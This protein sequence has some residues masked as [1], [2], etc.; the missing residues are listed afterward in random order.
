MDQESK[1]AAPLAESH[2]ETQ[3]ET[4]AETEEIIEA[5]ELDLGRRLPSRSL[6]RRILA[7]NLMVLAIP[8]GGFF[9]LNQI[10]ASL[11][12]QEFRG[13]RI[14]GETF[15]GALGASAVV[16]TP[17]RGQWLHPGR[18]AD[19]IRRLAAPT[20]T[21]ARLFDNNGALLADSLALGSP[22]GVVRIQELPPPRGWIAYFDFI[23]D[24]FD[25]LID[26]RPGGSELAPY[27]ESRSQSAA[28]Y[29]EVAR[30]LYGQYYGAMRVD[31]TGELVL[32]VAVPVQRF[33]QVVGAIMLSTGADKIEQGMREVRI[34]ILRVSA[35]ALGVTALL[36]LYLAG[37]I[38]RPLSRLA[39]AAQRVRHAQGRSIEIPDLTHRGDE[40]GN[41]SQSMRDMT[42]ALWARMDAIERFAAD[43]AHEIKNP[44]TS[45]RSAVET[46]SRVS[47]PDQQLRLFEVILEDV[48]RLDRLISD[49]SS[50]SRL[51]AELS[52]AE[53]AP[54]DLGRVLQ[55]VVSIANDRAA[56]HGRARIEL[57]LPGGAAALT[58]KAIESRLGQV[59][60]NVF[61]N[62]QS[63]APPDS[64]I[65]CQARPRGRQIVVTIDDSGPGIPEDSLESI[66][67]RF[68]SDRPKDTGEKFGTHSGLGLNISRQIVESADGSI[69]AANRSDAD[70]NILGARFS[71]ALPVTS[72]QPSDG[73]F[74]D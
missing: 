47:S 32:S 37:T 5:A 72:E 57:T 1:P 41:L 73:L 29:E 59:F 16:T 4:Q 51:D 28:D 39:A 25:R 35:I 23:Y 54:V 69:R 8:V 27:R 58:V 50:V 14:Q 12:D 18:S 53:A 20:A 67:D 38:A 34:G 21:R 42:T 55:A 17:G 36:S 71:I 60:S 13:L 70:G 11:I 62:A 9:F 15:A 49:I 19:L 52:R 63:F 30:A 33:R 46:V 44:L 74:E 56:E 61:S 10:E 64:T 6:T 45:L 7:I 68:Y 24:W 48:D 43:V 22:R 31:E 26:W 2:A 40:I 3:A 65:H 66:F